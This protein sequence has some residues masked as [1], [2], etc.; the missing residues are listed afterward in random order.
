MQPNGT[1]ITP[2]TPNESFYVVIKNVSNPRVHA[3][4][5]RLSVGGAVARPRTYGFE[6]L[7]A[8]ERHPGDHAD[9]IS[10][11]IGGGLQS[12]AMWVGVPMR[13]LIG[14]A[15]PED[16]VVEVLLRG[17][18]TPYMICTS[19]LPMW[20]TAVANQSNSRLGSSGH[21]ATQRARMVKLRSRN[22]AKR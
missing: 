6:D 9:C 16:G 7:R 8:A 17:P 20:P 21:A 18:S 14:D 11:A 4:V 10:N 5:W 15:G 19:S 12:N 3:S 1:G 13:D 22:Q 2:I